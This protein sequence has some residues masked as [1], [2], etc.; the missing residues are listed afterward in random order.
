MNFEAF[1][2]FYKENTPNRIKFNTWKMKERVI[3]GKIPPY[4]TTR[5]MNDIKPRDVVNWQN[6]IMKM[7]DESGKPFSPV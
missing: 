6:T 5:R 1:Y 7:T 3:E 4:F 2:Q